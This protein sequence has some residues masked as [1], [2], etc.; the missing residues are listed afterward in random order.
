MLFN[1]PIFLTFLRI[2]LIPLGVSIFY[3]PNF[4]FL[5]RS[6]QG[7]VSAIIF[8]IAATTDWLDG[9]LARRWKQTSVFGAFLDPVADKLMVTGAVLVL[10][11]LE[12]VHPIVA[13]IIIGREIIISALREW[14]AKIG[15]SKFVTVTFLGKIKTTVQM[16]AIF[17]LLLDKNLF[18]IF[19]TRFFGQ[20][21]LLFAAF[22]A[23]RSMFYYFCKAWPL[24]KNIQENK[25]NA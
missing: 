9:F 2:A 8:I 13:F 25:N 12:R 14:M 5:S 24:I 4:D 21:F 1:I 3:F 19:N 6:E 15:A 18:G 17:M 22:L 10:V 23:I 20:Q 7:V 16:F 11:H